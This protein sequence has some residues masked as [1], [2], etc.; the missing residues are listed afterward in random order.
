MVTPPPISPA[1]KSELFRTKRAYFHWTTKEQGT[2]DW[3]KN[4]LDEVAEA[5]A[6]NVIELHTYC[7]NIYDEADARTALITM[8]QSLYHAKNGRDVVSGTRIMSQFA[9]PKWRSIYKRIAVKHP[10]TRVGEFLRQSYLI[11]S[12]AYIT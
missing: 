12:Y 2:F 4:V 11:A 1:R 10:D 6:N 3:F 8:L 7:T 9:R 5:D